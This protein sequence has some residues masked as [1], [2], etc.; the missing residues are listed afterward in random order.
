MGYDLSTVGGRSSLWIGDISGPAPSPA[1]SEEEPV[2]QIAGRQSCRIGD[3]PSARVMRQLSGK[4]W[5]MFGLRRDLLRI[6]NSFGNLS[7]RNK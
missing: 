1:I 2:A 6:G 7:A 4:I 3:H 5:E